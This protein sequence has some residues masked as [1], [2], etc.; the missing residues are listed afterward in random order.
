MKKLLFCLF[1]ILLT[2]CTNTQV[3]P[4]DEDMN[5]I[6]TINDVFSLH[7]P[8]N[9]VF[10]SS[11]IPSN[12]LMPLKDGPALYEFQVYK[13]ESDQEPDLLTM[14]VEWLEEKPA[15]LDQANFYSENDDFILY[16]I[17]TS[18]NKGCNSAAESSCLYLEHLNKHYYH[19]RLDLEKVGES[20]VYIW[21]ADDFLKTI[22][23][24]SGGGGFPI[25]NDYYSIE[26]SETDGVTLSNLILLNEAGLIFPN[27]S[28]REFTDAIDILDEENYYISLN[29]FWLD[30]NA[31]FTIFLEPDGTYLF[32][33]EVKG[34]GPMC[35]QSLDFFK[36]ERG[37]FV[38][39][40]EDV[41]PKIDFD[42]NTN[43]LYELPQDSTV[44]RVYDQMS[45][46][47]LFE[48]HWIEGAFSIY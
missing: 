35:E 37:E 20:S 32:A 44:I 22:R 25:E 40:T 47:D 9:W 42:P 10:T 33:A 4:V 30:G 5:V 12:D 39:V 19:I 26:E 16:D 24:P 36:M 13:D 2:A 29:P 8:G 27:Y 11:E 41:L 23:N 28:G 6:L 18:G 14:E 1:L 48:L 38:N 43:P 17:Y 31:S 45:D 21:D 46:E 7:L 15:N 3:D 34:C